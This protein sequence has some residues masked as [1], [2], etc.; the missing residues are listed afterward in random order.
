MITQKLDTLN[1]HIARIRECVPEKPEDFGNDRNAEDSAVLNFCLAVQVC[2]DIAM[3]VVSH[4][5]FE[6]PE[7]MAQAFASLRDTGV[8]E[9]ETALKLRQ[10]CHI[11]NIAMHD[12]VRLNFK[13]LHEACTTHL[14]MFDNFKDSIQVWLKAQSIQ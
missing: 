2:V 8:L 1:E 10:A 6:R 9:T 13:T 14:S 5:G 12:Y 11:R 4:G 3:H 7:S